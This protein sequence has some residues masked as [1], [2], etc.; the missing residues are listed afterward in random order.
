M[1]MVVSHDELS[2]DLFTNNP[3]LWF[4]TASGPSTDDIFGPQSAVLDRYVD[5]TPM[6]REEVA[7]SHHAGKGGGMVHTSWLHRGDVQAA[8]IMLLGMWGLHLYLRD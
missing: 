1:A 6:L 8:A 2:D 4:S 5:G 7:L 3:H